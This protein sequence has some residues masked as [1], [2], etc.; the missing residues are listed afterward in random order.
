[1]IFFVDVP[2]RP[3]HVCNFVDVFELCHVDPAQRPGC[4]P[5]SQPIWGPLVH[6]RLRSRF[7]LYIVGAE[8]VVKLGLLGLAPL[9]LDFR[10]ASLFGMICAKPD[11]KPLRAV[12][13][14]KLAIPGF[15]TE[16][17]LSSVDL[18]I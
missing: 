15:L 6:L 8:A 2:A 16:T 18:L 17:P 1:M 5:K 9:W 12:R 7:Q 4:P 14:N 13:V 10:L 11:M 3:D